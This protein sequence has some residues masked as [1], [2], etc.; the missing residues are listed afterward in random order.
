[1]NKSENIFWSGTV[2]L[3]VAIIIAF[4]GAVT[5]AQ[6]WLLGIAF[7]CAGIGCFCIYWGE[8]NN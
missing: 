4:I 6:Y 1:M 5:H 8:K 7:I 3:L 2:L